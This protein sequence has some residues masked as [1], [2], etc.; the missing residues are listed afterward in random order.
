[1]VKFVTQLPESGF[2]SRIDA[3][4]HQSRE[5]DTDEQKPSFSVVTLNLRA[6]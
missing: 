6:I 5:D 1:M 3:G 2:D 4:F